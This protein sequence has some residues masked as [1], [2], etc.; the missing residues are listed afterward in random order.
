MQ[1]RKLVLL[2]STGSI[3]QSTLDVVV[4]HPGRFEV[5]ALAAHSNAGLLAEQC[6]RFRPRYVCIVNEDS[7][8]ELGERIGDEPIEILNGHDD[9]LRLAEMSEA[10]I[11]LNAVVGAAGL[12][13]SVAAVKAGNDLALA[14]KES[15]VAGGA[16][17]DKLVKKSKAR[18]LP[19]D[20]EHSAV[21]QALNCG[22]KEELRRIILTS[23][24][25]PFRTLPAEEFKNI[26]LDQ[27]L[28]HP[29]WN[30]GPKITVDSST[31]ANKGLEVIEAV[32][33]FQVPPDQVS[34]VVHPQSIVHSMVEFVDSSVIA[35]LSKPDMRLP[36]TCALFWPE[37]VGSDYGRLDLSEAMELTFEPP[38]YER[39]PA[40]RLAFEAAEAGGTAPAVYNAANEVAVEEFLNRRIGYTKIADTIA[41]TVD[42]VNVVS[43]PTLEQIVET[44]RAARTVARK[45]IEES[46]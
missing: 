24:G 26:T 38:D 18:I 1:P 7:R 23:S 46:Q 17:F 30:M 43:D 35:Q 13:A 21:W 41:A 40:L 31:L 29:T 33:L 39:F 44:D 15:M 10:D 9:L 28:D 37:R 19:V 22:R 20:S 42:N 25:G 14:N 32:A 16:L 3:G 45:L 12:R 5:I 4:Q 27:A 8:K 2:G 6:E 36:I 34:V 11:V